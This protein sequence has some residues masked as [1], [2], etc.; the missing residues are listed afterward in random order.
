MA[1]S[2]TLAVVVGRASSPPSVDRDTAIWLHENRFD[3]LS[4]IWQAIALLGGSAGLA[5]AVL[6]S[7]ALARRYAMSRVPSFLLMSFIGVEAL[8]LVMKVVVDRPR[9][10]TSLW[11]ATVASPSYPSGHTAVATA[12]GVSLLIAWWSSCRPPFRRLKLAGLVALPLVVGASRLALGV[13]WLTDVIGGALLGIGW[14]VLCAA[15]VPRNGHDGRSEPTAAASWK[16]DVRSGHPR[17]DSTPPPRSRRP[18]AG[19]SSDA[20]GYHAGD[21]VSGKS[22]AGTTLAKRTVRSSDGGPAVPRCER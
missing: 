18:S 19:R 6:A 13:H 9:P 8:V 12:V 21:R 16:P 22:H 4:V 20:I 15:I 1:A 5:V 7:C 3:S 2:G 10:P 17:T 11:L 14:V